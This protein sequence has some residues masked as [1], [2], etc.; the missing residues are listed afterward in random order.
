[1]A[2]GFRHF[3]RI[4]EVIMGSLVPHA[5]RRE[6]AAATTPSADSH[7]KRPFSSLPSPPRGIPGGAPSRMTNQLPHPALRAAFFQG[8]KSWKL[9]VLLQS[10]NPRA[11]QS[12]DPKMSPSPWRYST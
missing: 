5:L 4:R 8:G 9:I 2:N 7:K 10:Y 6:T 12:D 1:M 11:L 3:E